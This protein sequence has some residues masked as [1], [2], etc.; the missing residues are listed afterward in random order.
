[1][2]RLWRKLWRSLSGQGGIWSNDSAPEEL[3]W[4]LDKFEDPS[5]RQ[6][7][8][9][10]WC[11]EIPAISCQ[12]DAMIKKIIKYHVVFEEVMQLSPDV[13]GSKVENTL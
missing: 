10:S 12:H 7:L 13:Q 8:Q 2:D 4:K 3:H 11:C 9:S 1:M 5:R 6:A